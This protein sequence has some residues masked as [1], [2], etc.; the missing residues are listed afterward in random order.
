MAGWDEGDGP[1]KY[2]SCDHTWIMQG[3]AER[4]SLMG[5]AMRASRIGTFKA[6]RLELRDWR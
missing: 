2:T 3:N 1:P 5:I 6:K 4:D